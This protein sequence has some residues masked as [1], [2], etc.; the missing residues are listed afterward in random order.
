MNRAINVFK[1]RTKENPP[2]SAGRVTGYG[3]RKK[4]GEHY[5]KVDPH[6]RKDRK[7]RMSEEIG[8]ASCRERVFRAV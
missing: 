2:T 5:D 7:E 8:R 4:L 3:L 1:G 6:R